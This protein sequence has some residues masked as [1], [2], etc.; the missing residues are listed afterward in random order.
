MCWRLD[1]NYEYSLGNGRKWDNLLKE[2][3][4]VAAVRKESSSLHQ[5]TTMHI[6]AEAA[7]AVVVVVV[8]V[9]AVAVAEQISFW[10]LLDTMTIP[11]ENRIHRQHSQTSNI[12]RLAIQI[13]GR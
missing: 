13:S 10:L 8:V 9:V 5:T 7:A 11:P 3:D 6:A 1:K 4:C 2:R 12:Q